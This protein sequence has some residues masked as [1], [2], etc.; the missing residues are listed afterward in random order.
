MSQ[1]LKEF[2]EKVKLKQCINQNS[3]LD[4]AKQND[5]K[6]TWHQLY[7]KIRQDICVDIAVAT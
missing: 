4:V 3:I 7:L 6:Y 2:K 5:K 1:E